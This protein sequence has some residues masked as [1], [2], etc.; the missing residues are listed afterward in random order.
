MYLISNIFLSG[1]INHCDCFYDENYALENMELKSDRP[2]II[3]HFASLFGG[4]SLMLDSIL[5]KIKSIGYTGSLI[6]IEDFL[7]S[8]DLI[9]LT[10]SG[11]RTMKIGLSYDFSPGNFYFSRNPFSKKD[12]TRIDNFLRILKEYFTTGGLKVV[13]ADLDNTLIPGVFAEERT[14]VIKKYNTPEYFSFVYLKDFLINLCKHGVAVVV[15]SKND[16]ET[17][18]DA[19]SI[20]CPDLK[21]VIVGISAD[22]S[23]KANRIN[24]ILKEFNISGQNCLFIDDNSVEVEEVAKITDVQVFHYQPSRLTELIFQFA[25]VFSKFNKETILYYSNIMGKTYMDNE[26]SE[27]E[28]VYTKNLYRNEKGHF[29]RVIELSVKTNQMNFNKYPLSHEILNSSELVTVDCRNGNGFLGVVG[30]GLIIKSGEQSKL[31]QFVISCRALG[32][33]LEREFLNYIIS[34]YGITIENIV[35]KE[36]DRNSVA[37]LL[38]KSI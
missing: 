34:T 12:L 11:V 35:F 1:F 14:E 5:R 26:L 30:Y 29:E 10:S 7:T 8:S 18:D 2:V 36:T 3:F 21:E 38:L 9:K 25:H 28:T 6:F 13:F 37:K 20:L 19:L 31:E 32:F 23:S 4:C 15:V 22:Y 16:V 27:V 33:G 17:V 24:R